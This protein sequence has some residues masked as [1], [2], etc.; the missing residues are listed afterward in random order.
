MLVFGQIQ[1]RLE[2]GI[3]VTTILGFQYQASTQLRYQWFGNG[4]DDEP[5][6]AEV[7]FGYRMSSVAKTKKSVLRMNFCPILQ[8][9][10]HQFLKYFM[11]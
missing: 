5:R 6:F 7:W 1:I 3:H 10:C 4:L 9:L 8:H 2:I 11:L